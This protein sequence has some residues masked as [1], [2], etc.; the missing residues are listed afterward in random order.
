MNYRIKR[1]LFIARHSACAS[2]GTILT[3]L[4]GGTSC[5]VCGK[6]CRT[7][8]VCPDCRRTHFAPAPLD[9]RI[10]RICGRRLISERGLCLECRTA[11]ALTHTDG[12]FPLFSYRLWNTV[13]L[14]R[15]KFQGER[16]LSAFFAECLA[17]RLRQMHIKLGAFCLVPVPPRTGKIREHGW[18]QIE[19]M[20]AFLEFMHGF[21]VRQ[22][23]ERSSQTEQKS[24]DRRGRLATI[25]KSYRIK[26]SAASIPERVCIIDDVMTTGATIESCAEALKGAGVKK[27]YAAALFTVD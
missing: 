2:G 18:D 3:S 4:A 21:C 22:L 14:S 17:V 11:P 10:C 7:L 20:C 9:D 15:W 25:G 8:P 23:L 27:V 16:T 5:A 6:H 1:I 24:L 12:A 19:E 26:D 13:L